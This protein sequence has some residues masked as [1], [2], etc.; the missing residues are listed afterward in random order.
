MIRLQSLLGEMHM[1]MNESMKIYVDKTCLAKNPIAH[2]SSKH[3]ETRFHSLKDQVEKKKIEV[4]HCKTENQV[5][6][7]LTKTL[8]YHRFA[9]EGVHR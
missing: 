2:K 1:K 9:R 5:V 3:I 6:T 7:I 4:L 8:K